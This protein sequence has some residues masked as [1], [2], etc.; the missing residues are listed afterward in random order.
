MELMIRVL[1]PI[2]V[3]VFISVFLKNTTKRENNTLINNI[4]NE[5]IIIKRSKAYFVIGC[6]EIVF[7]VSCILLMTFSEN[8]TTYT[9]VYIV[10][11]LFLILGFVLISSTF[12]WK[13]EI[14]RNENYFVIKTFLKKRTVYYS[15]CKY[16]KHT[17][18]SL[19]IFTDKKKIS[20]DV[21][22]VN[23]EFML[24]MLEQYKVQ[25]KTQN[26]E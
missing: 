15:D 12:L 19:I 24:A 13:I 9:W 23:F 11:C 25:N 21:N 8:S 4:N 1:I 20:V 7:C 16:Y 5:H 18:N 26:T 17:L 3:S 2:I 10:F 14:F 22:C 6:V